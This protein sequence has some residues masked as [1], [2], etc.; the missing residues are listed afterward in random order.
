[1]GCCSIDC[2]DVNDPPPYLPASP[3]TPP[4]Q[5]LLPAQGAEVPSTGQIQARSPAGTVEAPPVLSQQ[6]GG[7]AAGAAGVVHFMHAAGERV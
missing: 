3:A 1:M 7:A 6:T 2:S 5:D 4:L